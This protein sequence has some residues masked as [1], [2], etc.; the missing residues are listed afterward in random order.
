M[1]SELWIAAPWGLRGGEPGTRGRNRVVRAA[2]RKGVG[3]EE[4]A[5][6]EQDVGGKASLAL[7]PGDQL[8]VETPGGGGYGPELAGNDRGL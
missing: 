5:G 2:G 1:I 4:P 8:V 6:E 7:E 3:G